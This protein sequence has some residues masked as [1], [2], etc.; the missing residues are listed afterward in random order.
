[1]FNNSIYWEVPLQ[2]MARKL[3]DG[4][5][6][7]SFLNY[8]LSLQPLRKYQSWETKISY[9]KCKFPIKS[10]SPYDSDMF[11]SIFPINR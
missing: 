11:F 7:F 1:M 9:V 2:H 8:C 10:H 6:H 4:Q 5:L 3:T